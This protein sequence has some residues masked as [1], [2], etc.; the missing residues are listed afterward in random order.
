MAINPASRARFNLSRTSVL[1]FD[2]TPVGMA[3]LVQIMSGF[4]AKQLHRCS[5][6]AE[7]KE[8]VATGT[9]DLMI[10]DAVAHS[11]EGYEFVRWVRHHVPE[12]N[13]YAPVLVTAAHSSVADVGR[14]RDCGGH[15]LVAKPIAPI[16]MLERIIW[17][18]KG[19]RAFVFSDDYVGP[20]RRFNDEGCPGGLAGRRREDRQGPS[21]PRS[22]PELSAL[23]DA[24]KPLEDGARR[25]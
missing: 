18:A 25:A 20:D 5:T 10:V 11:G 9:L 22:L 17:M 3:I 8:V 6:L 12:P 19:G 15:F 1:L 21:P 14:A 23:A 2:P 13:R 24:I 4:G 16:V 7:A